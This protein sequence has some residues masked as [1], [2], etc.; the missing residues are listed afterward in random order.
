MQKVEVRKEEV[1]GGI[2]Q[3]DSETSVDDNIDVWRVDCYTLEKTN[4]H[5]F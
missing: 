2:E 5:V 1:G 4:I 3:E